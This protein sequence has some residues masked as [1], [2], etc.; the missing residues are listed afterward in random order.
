MVPAGLGRPSRTWA[1]RAET[2]VGCHLLKAVDGWNDMGLGAFELGYL[3]DKEK[4]EVDFLVVR[5]GKPWFLAEVKH[6]DESIS[7]SLEYYQEQVKAPFAFQVVIDADYV[8]A[9]CFAKPRGPVVVPAKTFLSQLLSVP[10]SGRPQVREQPPR[11]A[12]RACRGRPAAPGRRSCGP[13]RRAGRRR[14]CVEQVQQ[15]LRVDVGRLAGGQHDLAASA[16]SIAT[17]PRRRA[18]ILRRITS[19]R[20]SASAGSGAEAVEQLVAD[21]IDLGVVAAARQA[22]V[23]HQALAHVGD[24]VLGQARGHRQADLR[25]D[26]GLVRLA[27]QLVDRL[28][29]HLHVGL[30]ADGGEVARLLGAEQVAGAADLEVEVREAE[31]AAE[32]R[33]ILDRL[34]AALRRRRVR[35]SSAGD[36]QVGVGALAAAADAAAQLVELREAQA[37]RRG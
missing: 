10:A 36:Q 31:A 27:A 7:G 29:E 16:T 6:R 12:R 32:L 35:A 37:R 26:L 34:E 23:E 21:A 14:A 9:D 24:V 4:R 13:G 22:L 19:T 18:R 30:V 17:T 25:V 20:F 33:E 28:L 1:T 8:E 2:F 11:G 3:R 15:P 5:D